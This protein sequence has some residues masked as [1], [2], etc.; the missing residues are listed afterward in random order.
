MTTS[1][2]HE[3]IQK[4]EERELENKEAELA[5]LEA[6]LIQRELDLATLRAELT[7]FEIQYLRTVGVLYAELDEIQA[8]IAE[9]RARRTPSDPGTQEQAARARTQ[10]QESSQTARAIGEP[11]S[12][13]TESLK[14]LFRE[15]AK[16]VHPDLAGNDAD[17]ARRQRLMAE[18]NRAYENGD[19]AKL[20]AI[21]DEW[22]TSPDSVEGEG[23]GPE[24]IRVIRKLA[25]IQRRLVKIE[26][27]MRQLST[28]DLY[29]LWLKTDEA[30][31]QERDLLKEIAS[32]VE[33]DIDA[34]RTRLAAIAENSAHA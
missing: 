26:A 25:Q 5:S 10:A 23:V 9:V 18:A 4:P 33:R 8:Q 11:K 15:V 13:P 19:D 30:E 32:Q 17:R 1:T 7:D 22:E 2:S 14:K 27:E 3:Q 28:S 21:L 34:A 24:L 6:N 31:N 29:K 12:K 20:Q 16:R